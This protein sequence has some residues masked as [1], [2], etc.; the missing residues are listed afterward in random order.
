MTHKKEAGYK[1]NFV[2]VIISLAGSVTGPVS[3]ILPE[4]P[5]FL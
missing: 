1:P 2:S 3:A 5:P 4:G